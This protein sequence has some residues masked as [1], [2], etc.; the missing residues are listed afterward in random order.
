M[1]ADSESSLPILPAI[2]AV[3]RA[4]LMAQTPKVLWLTGLSGA[5]KS[6]LSAALEAELHQR[7]FKTYL[8]DGDELRL[9]L[10]RGLGFDG[11]SRAENVR[12]AAEVARMMADAGLIVLVSMISPFEHDRK[13]ARQCIGAERFF[14][15]YVS[16]PLSVCQSRDPK[17]LY[18]S[19][20][21]GK[22]QSFTGLSSP[23]EP[24]LNADCVIDTSDSSVRRS[25]DAVLQR[26]LAG[27]A[28]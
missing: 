15:I 19:A 12:R 24:P 1:P 7:G 27:K 4:T 18:K 21:Q 22:I 25:V 17:G 13:L 16:T 26:F 10:C 8:I 5:G 28:G 20:E 23:Y 14:E 11:E 3:A 6:T 9:G 2:S